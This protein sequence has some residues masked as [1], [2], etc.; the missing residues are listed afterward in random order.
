MF[1]TSWNV[2]VKGNKM[3][4]MIEGDDKHT[5]FSKREEGDFNLLVKLNVEDFQLKE[6]KPDKSKTTNENGLYS[7]YFPLVG[8]GDTDSEKSED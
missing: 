7:Y 8:G 4:K 6:H 1:E 2:T 3:L 5:S